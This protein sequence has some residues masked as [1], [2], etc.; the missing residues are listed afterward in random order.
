MRTLYVD[1]A[2]SHYP[3]FIGQSILTSIELLAIDKRSKLALITDEHVAHFYLEELKTAFLTQG[4]QLDVYILKAGE[5]YKTLESWNAILTH[6]LENHHDRKSTLIALGGGVIGDMVGF[7]ASCYQRGIDFV[8]IPTSLLAQVDSSVGGKTAINHPLGK[9][10]IGTFYQPRFVLI[11]INTLK[12]LPERE[13]AAGMAE[14]IK[15]GVMM[16]ATF[17]DWL[18]QHIDGLMDLNASLLVDCVERCCKLKLKIVQADET[19][20]NQRAL[21]NL[22]HTFGHAIE[23]ELGFGKWLHGEAVSVGMIMACRLSHLLGYL[24]AADCDRVINLLEKAKLPIYSPNEMLVEQFLPRM[25]R[26]KKTLNQQLRLVIPTEIGKV[27]LIEGIDSA[28]ILNSI[29]LT[30]LD[31]SQKN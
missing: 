20:Q 30:Q 12:T 21:L 23:A 9:N 31:S 18:E 28:L 2:H 11:D 5:F 8:Q 7:A 10:L 15:Y 22:G 14:V 6:L 26:D 19:E 25:M 13:F 1:L 16:D 27:K 29:Q 17:F 24:S 4:Y 3:I